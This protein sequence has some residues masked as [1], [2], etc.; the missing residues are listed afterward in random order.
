[1][2]LNR[3]GAYVLDQKKYKALRET[4][5]SSGSPPS[6]TSAPSSMSSDPAAPDASP[7]AHVAITEPDEVSAHADAIQ[8]ALRKGMRS[9]S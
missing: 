5:A 8:S 2:I 6:A 3:N 7:Q 1:M 4:L 9:T